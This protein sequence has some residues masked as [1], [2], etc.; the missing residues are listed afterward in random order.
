MFQNIDNVQMLI[1]DKKDKIQ[2]GKKSL[3]E[4]GK[5]VS[6]IYFDMIDTIEKEPLH[7]ITIERQAPAS[8]FDWLLPVVLFS[9]LFLIQNI[10]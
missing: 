1:T 2:Q 8:L 4:I 7:E 5:S 3:N 6:G 9:I 10:S